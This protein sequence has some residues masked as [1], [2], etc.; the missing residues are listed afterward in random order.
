[1]R[2]LIPPYPPAIQTLGRAREKGEKRKKGKGTEK[3]EKEKR[4]REG[5]T[6]VRGGHFAPLA[7]A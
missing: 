6:E 1:L 7:E 3:V 4:K 2:G 5:R